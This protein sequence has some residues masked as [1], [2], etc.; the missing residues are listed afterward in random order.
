MID[1]R[2]YQWPYDGLLE[3]T[4]MGAIIIGPQQVLVNLGHNEHVV[5]ACRGLLRAVRAA[6]AKV[7]VVRYGRGSGIPALSALIPEE[8]TSEWNFIEELAPQP[9]DMVI[10]APTLDAYHATHLDLVLRRVGID[11]LIF[12]GFGTEAGIYAT[13]VTANDL[14]YE[15]LTV[16]NACAGVDPQLHEATIQMI[17]NVPGVYGVVSQ[18]STV[19]EAL[20]RAGRKRGDGC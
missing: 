14:G 19:V 10:N 6:G 16:A 15:C 11:R 12:C 8:G 1:A 7:I 3:P 17:I 9:D 13:L 4:R 2:P 20:G 18:A 5:W